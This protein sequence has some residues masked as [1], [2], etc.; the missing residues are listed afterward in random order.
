[1]DIKSL[2]FYKALEP[3]ETDEGTD[4]LEISQRHKVKSMDPG[5]LAF[6]QKYLEDV[7]DTHSMTTEV[8]DSGLATRTAASELGTE[9]I[10]ESSKLCLKDL[11]DD[12]TVKLSL[13]LQADDGA[14]EKFY[15]FFGLKMGGWYGSYPLKEIKKMFPD[16]TVS[17]LKECF[18]VLR[19]Y[20][21]V[22]FMEKVKP[23]SLRPA[24]YPEQIE[25][26][27]RTD[28]RSTKYHSNVAVLVVNHTVEEDIVE[29]EDAE[30]IETFFKDVN[31]RNEVAILSLASSQEAREFLMELKERNRGIGYYRFTEERLESV[32]QEKARLQKELEKVMQMEKGRKQR[33]RLELELGEVKKE[34]L[35][36]RG[37]LANVKRDIEKMTELEKENTKAIS[38]AMDEWIHN[39]EKFTCVAVFIISNDEL[40]SEAVLEERVVEKLALIPDHAKLVFSPHGWKSIDEV[41]ETLHVSYD[42]SFG[43]PFFTQMIEIFNKRWQTLD[44]IAMIQ[45][46][47]RTTVKDHRLCYGRF[48]SIKNSLSGLPTFQKKE[49]EHSS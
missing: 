1:L 36:L 20:D 24:V 13:R 33:R 11:S 2:L 16:T 26:L 42:S 10:N 9:E 47:K 43:L 22:E 37:K 23:R 39:Q 6:V 32:L 19:L 17:V 4:E 41:P 31:S 27:R 48:I 38:M 12:I 28:D 46:L 8:S 49:E 21:L 40:Y 14:L 15:Q 45:E 3:G 18:E 35:R 30:K 29:R 5:K 34:E 25:K 44:L 7:Q